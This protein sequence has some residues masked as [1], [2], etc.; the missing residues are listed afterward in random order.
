MPELNIPTK[1]LPLR[2]EQRRLT[3]V[4]VNGATLPFSSTQTRTATQPIYVEFHGTNGST[5]SLSVSGS[6]A[7]VTQSETLDLPS[8]GTYRRTV[9]RW[10]AVAVISSVSTGSGAI[11]ATAKFA[12][13]N[14][15]MTETIV[16]SSLKARMRTAR[17]PRLDDQPQGPVNA[18][19][20]YFY[21]NSFDLEILDILVINGVRYEVQTVPVI[22][23]MD[24]PHHTEAVIKRLR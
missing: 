2:V 7:G 24:A 3:N 11:T 8:N 12:D 4:L 20:F 21:C 23:G 9:S 19:R 22:Y 16:N 14:A 18:A 6:L 1:L 10:D 5:V 17:F 13:N 15:A